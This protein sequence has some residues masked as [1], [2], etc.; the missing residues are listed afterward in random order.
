MWG[1]FFTLVDPFFKK[2]KNQYKVFYLIKFTANSF[3][4]FVCLPFA[5]PASRCHGYQSRTRTWTEGGGTS[6]PHL[7]QYRQQNTL[8]ETFL[9]FCAP[10][11]CG[12]LVSLFIF[13]LCSFVRC[14]WNKWKSYKRVLKKLSGNVDN[15]PMLMITLWWCSGCW[16]NGTVV[17]PKIKLHSD[18]LLCNLI[19]LKPPYRWTWPTWHSSALF[20]SFT[21]L[22]E[23][24][25]NRQ[26]YNPSSQCTILLISDVL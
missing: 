16:G 17:L 11:R 1:Y 23:W 7:D 14:E 8:S 20:W 22:I 6:G 10:L 19:S 13:C 3:L 24:Q 12:K 26:K 15:G 21:V 4:E 5:S 9:V 2:K 25:R 18:L